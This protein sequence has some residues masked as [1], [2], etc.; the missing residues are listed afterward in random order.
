LPE[1]CPAC[2]EPVIKPEGEAI[3]RCTNASC[4][5]QLKESL[6]HWGSKQAV[7]IDG[8]GDKL[9][10]QLVEKGLV[11]TI[12]DLYG[13]KADQV[14]A[15]ERMAEKS[16]AN[17]LGEI[18]KS[19]GASLPRVTYGL[20][21]RHVGRALAETLAAEFGSL[22]A[23]A[24]ADEARL[25]ETPDV[26]PEVA[27]SIRAWF[28]SAR[29]RRLLEELKARGIAPEVQKAKKPQAGGP[30]EGKSIVVTGELASMSRDE[31][32]EAV[33][34]AGGS[35]TGSV[36]AKTDYLVV[37]EKPGSTKLRAAEKH[38]TKQ[39]DEDAFLRLIGRKAS[40]GS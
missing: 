33:R 28:K 21:I 10:D 8:L 17:L 39:I 22:Q 35:P 29:N 14:A 34:R 30:L 11:G 1:K 6:K 19:R 24:E 38:G 26:G 3:T 20:G 5:A 23:L 40:G 25:Q 13:L 37:G 32:E 7:D 15:L 31:A 36:S 9:V 2:G 18:E 4:P 12:S 27:A 16:A